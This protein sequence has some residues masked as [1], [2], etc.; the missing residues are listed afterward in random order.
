MK[1]TRS[2]YRGG[3]YIMSGVG[4]VGGGGGASAAG[5]GPSADGSA[6]VAPAAGAADSGD[7]SGGNGGVEAVGDESSG[8]KAGAHV[9]PPGEM[10]TQNFAQLRNNSVQPAHECSS[11]DMDLKKII[12]MMMAIKLLQEMNKS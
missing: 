7:F 1:C 6:A 12:E 10:S 5:A 11:P 3:A 8:G 4:G 2:T 9:P